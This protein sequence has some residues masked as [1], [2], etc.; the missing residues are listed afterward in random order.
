MVCENMDLVGCR[1]CSHR[2]NEGKKWI[3]GFIGSAAARAFAVR[4]SRTDYFASKETQWENGQRVP[5]GARPSI[6]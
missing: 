3:L 6:A 4:I 5:N 1:N 2:N